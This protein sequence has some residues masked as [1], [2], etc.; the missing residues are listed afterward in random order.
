MRPFPALLV[1]CALAAAQDVP[2]YFSV[3]PADAPELARR[4]PWPVG[5]RTLDIVNPGQPDILNY[6]SDT[7]QA[8]LYDRPLKI[9]IWYPAT[10]PAGSEE[11][12]LYQ[13]PMPRPAPSGQPQSFAIAGK[14]LRDAP[15][16]QR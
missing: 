11:Q 13:S 7:G 10:I 1:F 2:V 4:G 12:T 3:P 5:V 16:V 14:A 9:E 8:P 6:K 15:P